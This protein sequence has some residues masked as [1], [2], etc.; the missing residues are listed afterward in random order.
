M[1]TPATQTPN[2]RSCKKRKIIRKKRKK[3]V[4]EVDKQVFGFPTAL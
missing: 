2:K 4:Q 1:Q 3:N